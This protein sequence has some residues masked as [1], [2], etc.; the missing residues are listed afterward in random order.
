MATKEE[1]LELI[2]DIEDTADDM[3]TLI[4]QLKDALTG[5][6]SVP[7]QLTEEGQ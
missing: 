4:E 6:D 1:Q 7:I 3:V 2:A 5:T